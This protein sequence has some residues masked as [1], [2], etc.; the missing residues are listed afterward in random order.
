MTNETVEKAKADVKKGIAEVEKA[1]AYIRAD[2]K[3]DVEKV[4]ANFGK[5]D[6]EKKAAYAKADI[7]A[8]AKKAEADVE[9]KMSHAKA[10]AEKAKAD[11]GKKM[12]DAL[13]SNV[14]AAD[15]AASRRG[16]FPPPPS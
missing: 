1:G 10:D 9:N 14:A 7:K 2:A 8:D 13:K 16:M 5:S 6:V 4:K 11:I 12:A 3:A 15:P